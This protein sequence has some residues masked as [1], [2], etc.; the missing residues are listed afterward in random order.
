MEELRIKNAEGG[1]TNEEERENRNRL[2][3]ASARPEAD[4]PSLCF[5]AAEADGA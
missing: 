3:G 1:M 2:R 5:G 4:P